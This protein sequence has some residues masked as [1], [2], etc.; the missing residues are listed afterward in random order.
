MFGKRLREIRKKS[1]LTQQKTADDLGMTLRSY[2]RYEGEHCE[3][4]IKT[5]I[6]IADLFDV[7]LDYLLCRDDFIQSHATSSDER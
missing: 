5:L 2:Q 3:P 6:S 7:S 4:P 1:G